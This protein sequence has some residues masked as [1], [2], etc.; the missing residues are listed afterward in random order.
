MQI[1]LCVCGQLCSKEKEG[2]AFHFS[3]QTCPNHRS[4]KRSFLHT[5][6]NTDS[7]LFSYLAPFSFLFQTKELIDKVASLTPIAAEQGATGGKDKITSDNT[8]SGKQALNPA[9][10]KSATAAAASKAAEPAAAAT[11]ATSPSHSHHTHHTLHTYITYITH[12]IT[13]ITRH[14]Q[15]TNVLLVGG[16]CVVQLVQQADLNLG[17]AEKRRAIADDL[18]GHVLVCQHVQRF[19]D[20]PEGSLLI[21]KRERGG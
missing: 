17:L 13:H 19:D 21:I 8:A 10:A 11:A 6:D 9:K 18:D 2:G 5:G 14:S 15:P 16:I 4:I 7:Y 1:N 12:H 20:L 3:L